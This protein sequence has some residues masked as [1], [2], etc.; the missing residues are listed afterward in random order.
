M[1]RSRWEGACVQYFCSVYSMNANTTLRVEI[2][3]KLFISVT[4]VYPTS[5]CHIPGHEI[6][7]PINKVKS[8]T[9][10]LI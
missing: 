8:S 2:R 7:G 3:S 10:K 1:L 4:S 9:G 5:D 6:H